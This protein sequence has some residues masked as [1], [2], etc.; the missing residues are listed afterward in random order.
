MTKPLEFRS[1]E[2]FDDLEEEKGKDVKEFKQ[3]ESSLQRI[4]E[5]YT[6]LQEYEYSFEVFGKV[7]ESVDSCNQEDIQCFIDYLAGNKNQQVYSGIFLSGLIEV[8]R[9]DL[10]LTIPK[11]FLPNC[12]GLKFGLTYKKEVTIYGDVGATFGNFMESGSL[13]LHGNAGDDVAIGLRDG[14][15]IIHGDVGKRLARNM[16]G[17]LIEVFGNAGV[18]TANCMSGGVMKL[19][20]KYNLYE[21]INP[22]ADIYHK[23]ELIVKDGVRL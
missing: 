4:I 23:D 22:G 17:G 14:S 18:K 6:I 9:E 5:C 7:L 3:E 2:L 1:A 13:I 20:G 10:S 19:H 12:L 21:I 11:G 16:I 8:A 15:I